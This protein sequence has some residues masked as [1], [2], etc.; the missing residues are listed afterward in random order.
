MDIFIL[1]L[2]AMAVLSIWAGMSEARSQAEKLSSDEKKC[3]PHR[4]SYDA[5]GKIRCEFCGP[6][7]NL[8]HKPRGEE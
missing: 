6:M 5:E 3:P 8:G 2:I 7:S 4:W 1:F